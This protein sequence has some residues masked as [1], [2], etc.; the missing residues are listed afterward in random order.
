VSEQ[1]FI[2]KKVVSLFLYPM[3][4]SIILMVV[5]FVLSLVR[6]RRSLGT[7]LTA[8][9][10][11]YL[12]IMSMPATG[13]LLLTS[14]EEVAGSRCD[15][16]ALK[17]AGVRRIVVLAAFPVIDHRTPVDQWG[18]YAFARAMEGIRLST[19]IPDSLLVLSGG[20]F[21]VCR[22]N[23]DALAELSV[24]IGIRSERLI[25]ETRAADTEDEVNFFAHI[26]GREPFALVTSA[27]HMPRSLYLFKSLGANP[28]PCPYDFRADWQPRHKL[29]RFVPNAGS[30]KDSQ[31]AIHEHIG[32]LWLR[33]RNGF[34]CVPR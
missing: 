9:G 20:S 26:V 34:R 29:F 31:I 6:P 3:G 14:L 12:I 2:L 21:A 8:V 32:M 30:L 1:L 7:V 28:I 27:V 19:N 11:V 4:T 5:G 10:L 33:L 18:P 17:D 23:E 13:R 16:S 22:S 24:D 15:P 25:L